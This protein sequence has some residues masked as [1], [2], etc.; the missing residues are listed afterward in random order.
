MKFKLTFIIIIITVI[1]AFVLFSLE[2]GCYKKYLST[3]NS[4]CEKEDIKPSIVLAIIKTESNFNKNAV[5]HKGAKGLMQLMPK[6]A[7]YI[8]EIAGYSDY[9]L[10]SPYDNIYLGVKYYKYLLK[11]FGNEKLSLYAYN[12]GEGVVTGWLND[13]VTSI[14]YK[15]TANY[16]KKVSYRRKLYKFLLGE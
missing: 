6:T 8:A 1:S 3:V 13:N 15:E 11:K 4:V 12:A 2:V 10:F 9:D 7:E 16:Y 14:P 5:S